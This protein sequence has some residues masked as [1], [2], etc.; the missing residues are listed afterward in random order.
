[1]QKA[2]GGGGGFGVAAKGLFHLLLRAGIHEPCFGIDKHAAYFGSEQGQPPK[3]TPGGRQGCALSCTVTI[4]ERG[5]AI[6]G[7]SGAVM[8]TLA[9]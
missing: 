9:M 3:V 4:F 2:A 1:M 8:V 6:Y 7:V 5:S